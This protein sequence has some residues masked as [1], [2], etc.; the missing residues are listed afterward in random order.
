MIFDILNEKGICYAV[1]V[2][3]TTFIM[4]SVSGGGRQYFILILAK[5]KI[6]G[7]RFKPSEFKGCCEKELNRS[8]IKAFKDMQDKFTKIIHN[9]DGRV[10]ELINNSFKKYYDNNK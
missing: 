8:E 10:Y 5:D 1:C 9:K 6:K 2:S 7:F 3:I 4:E